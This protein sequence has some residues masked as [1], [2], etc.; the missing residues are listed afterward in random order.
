MEPSPDGD[1]TRAEQMA[2]YAR[3]T[4]AD[5]AEVGRHFGV[6]KQA[7][8]Q[9]LARVDHRR[10]RA[11]WSRARYN[12]ERAG[13]L[14]RV[15]ELP[16]GTLARQVAAALVGGLSAAA[17]LDTLAGEL[18]TPRANLH[19]YVAGRHPSDRTAT[20]D[21]RLVSPTLA[22]LEL[23]AALWGIE[24]RL[25]AVPYRGT[26]TKRARMRLVFDRYGPQG[27]AKAFAA[28]ADAEEAEPD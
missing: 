19:Q 26:L 3:E 20:G 8:T 6:S 21:R 24:W 4:G 28:Y 1:G 13:M 25:T 2:A 10:W 16:E 7:V 15:E 11:G 14:A 23:L 12:R 27:K 18:G 22:F 5:F 17:P 9:A